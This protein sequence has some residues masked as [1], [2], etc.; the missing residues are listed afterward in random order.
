MMPLILTAIGENNTIKKIG[1]SSELKK[2][3]ND[4]GLTVGGDIK[5][6]SSL[7]GNVIISVKDSRIALSRETAAKIFI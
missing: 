4:L 3:L 5:I 6:V 1:G 7:G 2:H